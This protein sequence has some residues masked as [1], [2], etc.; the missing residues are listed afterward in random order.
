MNT[1]KGSPWVPTYCKSRNP[2]AELARFSVRLRGSP[3]GSCADLFE[4]VN[5]RVESTSNGREHKVWMID[6]ELKEFRGRQPITG[7]I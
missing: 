6:E 7:T 4:R 2:I 1:A 3:A 5:M